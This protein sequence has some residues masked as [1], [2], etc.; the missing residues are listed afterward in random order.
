MLTNESDKIVVNN[1]KLTNVVHRQKTTKRG[2]N[3]KK[4]MKRHNTARLKIFSAN[5][6]GIIGGKRKSLLS[7]VKGTGSN[8]VTLQETHCRRKGK[9]MIP[10]MVIFEAIR[11][12]KGGGTL[13][14]CHKDLNP[15]LV[16]EYDDELELLVV[17]IKLKGKQ[18]RI[19]SGYGPQETW[20]EEKRRPFFTAL[21]TEI[22]RAM[23]A[24]KSLIVEM[25]ANSKLGAKYIGKDPHGISQN[26]VILASIVERHQLVVV[27]G[28]TKCTGTITRR[29]VTKKRVEE[30]VIDIVLVSSDMMENLVEMKVDEAKEHVLTKVTKT[31]KGLKIKESDHNTIVTEFNLKLDA[32][33]DNERFELYNLKNKECQEQFKAYTSNTKILSSIFD[34]KDNLDILNARFKK[35]LDGCIAT[36]FKKIRMSQK[37]DDSED[38]HEQ[39]RNLKSKTDEK[40]KARLQ[41]ILEK[42]AQDARK[43]FETVRLEINKIRTNENGMNSKKLWKMKKKLCPKIRP[44]PTA[45][46]DA[47]GKLLT[48]D[49]EIE[50]RALEVFEKRLEGN[51][52]EDE[53]KDV[54]A[55]NNKLC[56]LQLKLSKSVRTKPWGM[57]DLK[58]AL[59]GLAKDKSRDADGY[60][61]ELF[62]LEVAGDDLLLAVFKLLNCI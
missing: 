45:M 60:A 53:L 43:N 44:P 51:E 30:S 39:M 20:V 16:E 11:N 56:E 8:V 55:D 10:D 3:K 12:V 49:K 59:K 26:G 37:E 18:I 5:G 22:E 61:N 35:K 42:I 52:I 7:E 23:L 47:K 27:N 21:E 1:S 46:L 62:A 57:E 54:E 34:S 28:S 40:S 2:F 32:N 48:T 13:V 41:E 6:A 38:L 31:K 15:K 29:R 25:D 9:I 36:S 24:G 58:E 17:E 19:I 50:E 33:E 14:A 4:H